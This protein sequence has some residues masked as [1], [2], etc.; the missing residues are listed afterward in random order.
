M[1]KAPR[2]PFVNRPPD[3][4]RLQQRWRGY[5]F[6]E[7]DIPNAAKGETSGLVEYLRSDAPLDERMR[8]ALADLIERRLQSKK[9]PGRPRGPSD[10]SRRAELKRYI[11]RHVRG[12]E[13]YWRAANPNKKA[14][15]R[16]LRRQYIT[17]TLSS[18]AEEGELQDIAEITIEEISRDLERGSETASTSDP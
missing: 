12:R 3:P 8:D 17:E 13:K 6:L 1:S 18:L 7:F 11:V 14:L 15:R 4:K 9:R 10:S 2:K 5:Q 16:G